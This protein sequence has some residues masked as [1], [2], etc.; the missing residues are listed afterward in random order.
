VSIDFAIARYLSP[1]PDSKR[2]LDA[3]LQQLSRSAI[4]RAQMKKC[5][6]DFELLLQ[7]TERCVATGD[8]ECR[9]SKQESD[10]FKALK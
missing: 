9:F 4:N 1:G 3:V 6:P 2:L 10:E 8:T 5:A 7:K